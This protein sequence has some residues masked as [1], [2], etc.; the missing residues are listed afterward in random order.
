[1]D[2]DIKRRKIMSETLPDIGTLKARLQATW[3]AG[4][5]GEIAKSYEDGAV[6]IHQLY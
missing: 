6:E 5:F 1:M 3:A 4:N 2:E